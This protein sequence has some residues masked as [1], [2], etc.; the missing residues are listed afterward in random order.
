MYLQRCNVARVAQEVVALSSPGC[1]S[2][3]RNFGWREL[4]PS[5][6]CQI[7]QTDLVSNMLYVGSAVLAGELWYIL[8]RYEELLHSI[9][10]NLLLG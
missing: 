8:T 9:V 1:Q 2:K 5:N 10:E 4:L 3:I 7:R 6:A